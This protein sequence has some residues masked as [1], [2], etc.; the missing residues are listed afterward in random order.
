MAFGSFR[1]SVSSARLKLLLT[2]RVERLFKVLVLGGAALGGACGNE[3]APEGGTNEPGSG[4][5]GA[6]S[7][8]PTSQ[9]GSDGSSAAGAGGTSTGGMA[10]TDAVG[11]ADTG[12]AGRASAG[13]VGGMQTSSAGNSPGGGAG[14]AGS[15]VELECRVDPNGRGD[16]EDPCG[17][18]CCW[19][20][21]CPNTEDCCSGFCSA[22]DDGRGCCAVK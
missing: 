5:G 18:P 4:S 1:Y 21:D 13:G 12:G 3:A 8:G 6:D 10:G 2:M 7:P 15:S 22:G 14:M 11:A 20:L 9:G 19:A 17:C 16:P